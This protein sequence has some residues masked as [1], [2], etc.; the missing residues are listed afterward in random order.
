MHRLYNVLD[1]WRER[2]SNVKG[3]PIP[4]GHF[5]AEEKSEILLPEFKAFLDGADRATHG[6]CGF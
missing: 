4:G 2:A 6:T 3:K 5:M 1:T